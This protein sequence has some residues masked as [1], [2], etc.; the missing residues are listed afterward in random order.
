MLIPTE[1]V[2]ISV[3]KLTLGYSVVVEKGIS[4][5]MVDL[6]KVIETYMWI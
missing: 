5:M 1:V 3:G 6:V 4:L 2:R